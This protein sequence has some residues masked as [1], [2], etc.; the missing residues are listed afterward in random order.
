MI[1]ASIVTYHNPYDMVRQ[2]VDSV[3]ASDVTTLYIVDH[4]SDHKL[5]CLSALSPRIDY[6]RHP[7]L[8]YGSGHNLA[9][10]HALNRGSRYHAVINPDISFGPEV[11]PDIT[12]YM[13]GHADVGM[14]MPEI[15]YPDGR[16]Q[17]HCKM[18]P[19]PY[20]LIARRFLPKKLTEKQRH[21]FELRFSGYD[22]IMNIP[23]LCGCF[24]MLRTEALR[25]TGLFD[26]RF[27]MYPE[28]IDLTRRMHERFLTLYYPKVSVTHA[29]AAQSRTNLRMLI[30]H[31]VNMIRYFN[32]WGWLRDTKRR[33][34]NRHLLNSIRNKTISLPEF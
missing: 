29:Y 20:D 22:R 33:A 6:I 18:V 31:A 9:I 24:M 12:A 17:H 1:T 14:I 10:R 30:I 25:V 4:S 34:I 15:R 5:E 7:N 27:F 21:R 13:D 8:G 32:K 3:L 26:E 28:D 19:T 2:A 11:L 16:L 23:Y